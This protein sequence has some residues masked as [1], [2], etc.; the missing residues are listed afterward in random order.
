MTV[1]FGSTTI[2]DGY[3]LPWLV[4]GRLEGDEL[5]HVTRLYEEAIANRPTI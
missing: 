1:S 3:L 5:K 2:I 4:N